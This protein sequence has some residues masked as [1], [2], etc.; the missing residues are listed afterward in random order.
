M[1]LKIP[2]NSHEKHLCQSLLFIKLHAS[3]C[4][5][6]KKSKFCKFCEI[7]ENTFSYR[8]SLVAASGLMAISY[9][10]KFYI[11]HHEIYPTELEMK[12]ERIGCS[13]QNHSPIVFCTKDSLK[14]FAKFPE[15][16][17]CRRLFLTK[18]QIYVFLWM[19]WNF[20]EHQRGPLGNTFFIKHL[21][22]LL[23]NEVIHLNTNLHLN[24]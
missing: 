6:I 20:I 13:E 23:L 8:T 15:K 4:N 2:Q 11:D 18:L 3:S 16:H 24:I 7:S 19:L 22:W 12:K 1:F 5:L 21:R 9:Y 14:S 17:L 10:D